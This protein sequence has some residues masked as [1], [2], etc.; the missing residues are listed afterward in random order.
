[1]R[2]YVIPLTRD[3]LKAPFTERSKRA[4]VTI[5][6]F[7]EKHTRVEKGK[8]I[9]GTELNRELWKRG[10][11][12]PPKKV[13]VFVQRLKDNKVF[14]NLEGAPMKVEKKKDE[15]KEKKKEEKSLEE[16]TKEGKKPEKEKK[17]KEKK[18]KKKPSKPKKKKEKKK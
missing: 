16:L 2:K 14:V 13:K 15:K 6:K 11:K 1:M 10:I 5:K 4:V 18:S 17:K 12:K 8:V 3:G 9:I 7:V